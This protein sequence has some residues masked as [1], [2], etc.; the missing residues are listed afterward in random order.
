MIVSAECCYHFLKT[1][2]LIFRLQDS[3]HQ[4]PVL[5]R[6]LKTFMREK[7]TPFIRRR[8]ILFQPF[9]LLRVQM[10]TLTRIDIEIS[11]LI[12]DILPVDKQIVRIK[13]NE[14]EI[15]FIK[16]IVTALHPDKFHILFLGTNIHIM[17]A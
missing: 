15:P 2:S 3:P 1:A 13:H 4:F 12:R 10:F 11:I 8:Q 17:I 14:M 6:I 7:D 16:R 9:D 5:Y